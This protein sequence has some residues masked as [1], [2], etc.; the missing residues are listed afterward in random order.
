M[1]PPPAPPADDLFV[2]LLPAAGLVALLAPPFAVLEVL[3][4]EAFFEAGFE[5]DAPPLPLAPP[6]GAS[7]LRVDRLAGLGTST[8]F[9]AR[10]ELGPPAPPPPRRE[11]PDAPCCA[12]EEEDGGAGATVVGAT[13]AVA[14][15]LEL[16]R[17]EAGFE[18]GSGA[19][20]APAVAR[21]VLLSLRGRLPPD[22][23]AGVCVCSDESADRFRVRMFM[24]DFH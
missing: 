20:D 7:L 10:L 18:A 13:V 4:P 12:A 5:A 14:V 22:D 24:N 16:P 19:A 23:A 2:D 11:D 17:R 9:P 1:A 8:S 21:A 3:E 6:S 15:A